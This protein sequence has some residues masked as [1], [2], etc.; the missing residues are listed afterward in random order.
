[1]RL[2]RPSKFHLL[3]IV[4][5][6]VSRHMCTRKIPFNT[7]LCNL[8]HIGMRPPRRAKHSNLIRRKLLFPLIGV[9]IC[10]R[11]LLSQ[12]RMCFLSTR[13]V[14]FS[15]MGWLF[16]RESSTTDSPHHRQGWFLGAAYPAKLVVMR[17]W[18]SGPVQLSV[19][20]S[21][22][23]PTPR[24]HQSQITCWVHSLYKCE[25]LAA[26]PRSICCM[27]QGASVSAHGLGKLF[28]FVVWFVRAAPFDKKRQIL[29]HRRCVT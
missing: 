24:Q 29:S 27:K 9:C 14:A 7:H 26:G 28:G 18:E 19:V 17:P 4:Y 8:P 3:M 10:T 2:G 25:R 23:R 5:R 21:P 22:L 12:F 13:M 6:E 16:L 1:M 20:E 11:T 15:S